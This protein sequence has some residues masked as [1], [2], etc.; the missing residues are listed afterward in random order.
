MNITKKTEKEALSKGW[1]KNFL[2]ED[3][4]IVASELWEHNID[5]EIEE[6]ILDDSQESL[7]DVI[8]FVE[9]LKQ[10]PA[11]NYIRTDSDGHVFACAF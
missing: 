6:E 5:V 3:Y 4:A 9:T 7:E 10:R 8:S 11:K 2:F 1:D